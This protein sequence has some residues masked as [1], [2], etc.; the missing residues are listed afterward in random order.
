[1]SEAFLVSLTSGAAEEYWL[2][3][4]GVV[5]YGLLGAPLGVV[6]LMLLT[7]IRRRRLEEFA[8]ARWSIALASGLPLI[9][10]GR[11]HVAQRIFHESLSWGS[12]L[13]IA[14]LFVIVLGAV[15]CGSLGALLVGWCYRVIGHGVIPG[16]LAALIVSSGA[17]GL[18]SEQSTEGQVTRRSGSKGT[19]NAPN[20]ILIVVD[21]LRADAVEPLGGAAGSTPAFLRLAEQAVTFERAYAQSSWTRPSI[22]SIL[23]SLHPSGHGAIGKMD[24]LPDPVLTLAEAL[25]EAGY[26]T[27]GFVTNINVA[28]VF[29]FQQGFEEYQ[30]LEPDFYF[31]ATDSATKLAIYKG[32][33]VLRE[34][35][36][37]NR[38]YFHHYYQDAAVLNRRVSE[39]LDSRPPEPFFLLIHYMDPHDPFF[40]IPY[41]GRGVARVMTPSPPPEQAAFIRDLY[42]Q[43][44]RYL[45]EYLADFLDHLR[46]RGLYDRS[47][48]AL[49]ADHG[50][51]FQEHGGWWHGTTLYEEVVH[52]PLFIKRA[53]EP[54]PGSRRADPVR[55]IDVAPTLMAAASLSVPPEF[56][57]KDLFSGQVDGPL[58]AEED[59]EGNRLASLHAGPWKLITA[60][61][62]NPRGLAAI[63]LYNLET[64]PGE[65][66][67]LVEEE[68]ARVSEMLSQL[69]SYQFR[70]VNRKAMIRRAMK[71]H[72]DLERN[73]PG[74]SRDVAR[75]G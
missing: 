50:E 30:Y 58:V 33:R 43:D 1:V 22:A 64:D 23:T 60:N 57:G 54:S 25:R 21:T 11:Y 6:A 40:E 28:P 75:S 56:A 37:S 7:M 70:I 8:A 9:A 72:E 69:E 49:T 38:M 5:S 12:V 65:Q 26:W 20:V 31:A 27:A 55:T 32:L 42:L 17:L 52:V 66:R 19:P 71:D 68:P 15:G 63:E 73:A 51:E 53:S 45:D 74:A 16:V 14:V 34:R 29:N 67:N 39:W 3:L 47:V 36:F 2:F 24:I 35:F 46:E 48:V 41:N 18:F 4:F 13:G 61:V 10:L 62:G 59:L 44:V